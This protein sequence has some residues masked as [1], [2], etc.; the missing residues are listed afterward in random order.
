M[1]QFALLFGFGF[2]SAVLLV[3]ILAP[4]VHRR[5]VVYTENRLKATM[6]ISPSEVRAQR[7]MARA[8]Y[9]A[10]NARTKQELLQERDKAVGMQIRFDKLAA[11]E[12]HG[13][14]SR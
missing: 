3:M 4:A 6:P 14:A 10:E 8:V 7:D 11:G 9:A 2:L 1:I 13:P 5:V 12:W